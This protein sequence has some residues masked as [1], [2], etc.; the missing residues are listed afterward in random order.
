M[1]SAWRHDLIPILS[2]SGAILDALGGLYLAYDL[3]G[4]KNGPLRAVTKSASYRVLFGGAYGLP[5]GVW[6]GLAGLS[7]S[8]PALSFEIGRPNVRD[9]HQFSE[10]P[11]LGLLRAV[12]FGAAGWLSKDSWFGVKFGIFCAV[13]FVATYLIVGPPAGTDWERPRFN[14][15]VL[16]RAASRGPSLGGMGPFLF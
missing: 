11:R 13:G 5:L 8:G 6:F 16:K 12:S 1:S 14:K 7:V 3:V 10:A 9:F 2:L 15:A 4:G